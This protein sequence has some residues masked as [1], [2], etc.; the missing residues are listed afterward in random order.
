MPFS[1]PWPCLADYGVHVCVYGTGRGSA[2]HYVKTYKQEK[3]TI[4]FLYSNKQKASSLGTD[5]AVTTIHFT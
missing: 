2:L 1:F 3:A 4:M 5:H